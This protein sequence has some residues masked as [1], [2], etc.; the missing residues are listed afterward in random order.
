MANLRQPTVTQEAR[1]LSKH[2]REDQGTGWE[3]AT[4]YLVTFLLD[5]GEKLDYPVPEAEYKHLAVGQSG[6]LC[7]RGAWYR[8]FHPP[9]DA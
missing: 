8:G 3:P 7:R 9:L 2:I 6:R 1:V 4:T 5:S